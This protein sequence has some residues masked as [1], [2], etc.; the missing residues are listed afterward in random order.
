MKLYIEGDI[1]RYYVQ[2]LCLIFFPGA[3]FSEREEET[4]ESDAVRLTLREDAQSYTAE[5]IMRH[6]GEQRSASARELRDGI[7][8]DERIKKRA[9]GRAIFEAGA[10][11]FGIRPE[12]GILTGVRP[13]KLAEQLAESARAKG[14]DGAREAERILTGD[15]LA[16]PEKAHLLTEVARNNSA[17][18]GRIGSGGCSVYIS[19]PFCPTRC[20]YCSFVSYSTPRLLSL[21]PDYLE[22][23]CSDIRALG[24]LLPRIGRRVDTVYIGGGTPTTLSGEQ[25]DRLLGCIGENI[26]LSRL[27]EFTLEAG[28]P[29]TITDDKLRAAKR[30]GVTRVSINPQTTN[31]E[32][33]RSIGRS[34]T[35]EEFFR[36]YESAA[37]QSFDCINTDLI[38]GLPGERGDS[39]VRSF[40]E[41]SAL[42]PE[43]I[44]VHTFC[45]KRAAELAER[46]GCYSRTGE[47]AGRGVAYSQRRCAELGYEPYYMYKQKNA[48]G[49]YENVGFSK[50]GKEGIYNILIMD[51]I[52][53]IFAL[54]AG[55][56]TKLVSRSG[57]DMQRL[58][59]P[60]YPYEYLA[61]SPEESERTLAEAAE[62]FYR[63]RFD[64]IE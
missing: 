48:V 20:A 35:A 22:R 9:V 27:R 63:D 49:G 52:H 18:R 41:V 51:E 19:I 33:L 12:W 13:A 37:A 15:Y 34:H 39:F 36:A 60:K 32:V 42:S 47:D 5:A 10:E 40:D 25:L 1:G 44:T 46:G 38:A 56:V 50:P 45:V 54:G 17:L 57:G 55:A 30:G 14:F 23:L 28:R 61:A 24:R 64:D 29:D 16:A 62:S 2:T 53:S 8:S 43:N 11:L 31:D 58:F 4:A 21:I 59:M 26:D 6:G 7:D 3:G